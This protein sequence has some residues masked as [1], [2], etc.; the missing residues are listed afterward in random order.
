MYETFVITQ[1]VPLID[2]NFRT[3]DD[4]AHRAIPGD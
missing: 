4:R 3:K 1:L 2:A